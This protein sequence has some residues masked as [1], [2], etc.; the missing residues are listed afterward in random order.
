MNKATLAKLK[1]CAKK[2]QVYLLFGSTVEAELKEWNAVY[3][4]SPD[5]RIAGSQSV[6]ISGIF[7]ILMN[8]ITPL[9]II[10]VSCVLLMQAHGE[11]QSEKLWTCPIKC[12]P[13]AGRAC[14]SYSYRR[15]I[16]MMTSFFQEVYRI[17]VRPL[18]RRKTMKIVTLACPDMPI[19][20]TVYKSRKNG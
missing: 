12:W 4:L 11:W 5:G 13:M 19:V 1:M 6:M 9:A 3:I 2:N 20:K 15:S 7:S 10:Y 16:F 18:C 8:K 17:S 14:S